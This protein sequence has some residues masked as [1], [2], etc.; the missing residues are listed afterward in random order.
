MIKKHTSVVSGELPG[1]LQGQFEWVKPLRAVHTPA[2]GQRAVLNQV[3]VE[4]PASF[5]L[6]HIQPASPETRK[7]VFGGNK[8]DS[9]NYRLIQDLRSAGYHEF[10]RFM[11][12]DSS[13][14]PGKPTD[15]SSLPWT[16]GVD[17]TKN[18]SDGL[19]AKLPFYQAYR[20]AAG[21]HKFPRQNG[22]FVHLAGQKYVHRT[23]DRTM[24]VLRA[25]SANRS[26]FRVTTDCERDGAT[27][28]SGSKPRTAS[29]N[30][31][32]PSKFTNK[33]MRAVLTPSSSRPECKHKHQSC[34]QANETRSAI[35]AFDAQLPIPSSPVTKSVLGL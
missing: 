34:S 29:L 13:P 16:L 31:R 15:L 24:E 21:Q 27:E 5:L 11:Y 2:K 20:V 3:S 17:I 7:A 4:A 19:R 28:E 35:A 12:E 1:Y 22:L 25:T 33:H 8:D 18:K 9:R 10:K 23:D 26:R 14:S 32:R 30:S 6:T